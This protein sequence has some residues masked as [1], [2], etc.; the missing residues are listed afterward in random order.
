MNPARPLQ[1]VLL[2]I[3]ATCSA[4]TLAMTDAQL[5]QITQQRLLGD[6]TGACFAVA[7]IDAGAKR[8]VSRAVVCADQNSKP[9]ISYRSAFEIGSVTKT[10]TAALWA[11]RIAEGKAS[12][13][14]PI[15]LYLP[16]GTRVPSFDGQPILLQHILTHTSGLPVIPDFSA[17]LDPGNPYAQID[18]ASALRTLAQATLA[19]APGS[20]FEYSN[21]AM[22]LGTLMLTQSTQTDFETLLQTRLFGPLG[23]KSSYVNIQPKGIEAA[24]G[25]L[26]NTQPA[27]AWTFQTNLAGAGGVKA[28]LDDM[29]HYVQA[30][31]GLPASPMTNALKLSQQPIQTPAAHPVAMNWMLAKPFDRTVHI[32]EGGTGGFS[33]YVAFDLEEQ[34]G[35]VVLSDTA[36][37]T[38]GGLGSL[39]NHLMDS[40]APLGQPRTMQTPDAALL[41]QLTGEYQPT[42]GPPMRISREGQR[43]FIQA[44]GQDKFELGYDSAGDFYPLAF[45]ALLRPEKLADGQ[46][47]LVWFQG[48]AAVPLQKV[49]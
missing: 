45:D 7:V 12:L 40:R 33:A 26:P 25:H 17:T 9:R 20:M 29:T 38:L 8:R 32:H 44:G 22:M 14:D 46:F 18:E 34:R 15:A 4:T 49:K 31:L 21:F 2:A 13:N 39:G 6:R 37:T 16:K 30:Q 35:V 36:L 48:G 27:P 23:M 28:T 42:P 5:K 47:K 1:W 24:R 3:G 19:R 41:D 11:D 43:L 10:M